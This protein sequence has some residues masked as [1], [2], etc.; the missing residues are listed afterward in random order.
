MKTLELAKKGI[1]STLSAEEAKQMVGGGFWGDVA[2]LA[3]V[4]VHGAV[5]FAKEGGSNAGICVR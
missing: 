5:V 2:W 4:I 3:G 1:I